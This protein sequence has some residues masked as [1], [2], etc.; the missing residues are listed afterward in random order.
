MAAPAP[1]PDFSPRAIGRAVLR[2]TLQK[3]YVLY[4]MAV[5]VLGGMAAAVLGPSLLFVVPA[6]LGATLGFG[7]WAVDFGLRRDKHASDYIKRLQEALAGRVDET[8][9][10]LRAELTTLK[11]EPGLAQLDHL[12]EKY[13]AFEGLLRRKLDPGEMTFGRYLGMTEQVF[14]AGLDNLA[15]VADTLKGLSAIDVQH[16]SRR[17]RQLESDGIESKAQDAEIATL[18]E[19][20]TLLQARQERVHQWLAENE[21]AM[22]RIDQAMAAIADMDT[23]AGHATMDMETAMLELKSL[24]DRAPAYSRQ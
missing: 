10:A 2:E 18:R 8:I 20:L 14:L 24:A 5:G 7:S 1:R 9:A 12:K 17:I 11:F 15:R 13:E 16:I 19:R 6:A 4:P 21:I 22:T 23:A 3:P